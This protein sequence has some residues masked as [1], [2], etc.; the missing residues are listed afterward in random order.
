MEVFQKKGMAG[1]RVTI[2]L[3]KMQI[4]FLQDTLYQAHPRLLLQ[5]F[6]LQPLFR[7]VIGPNCGRWYPA[8]HRCPLNFSPSALI[9]LLPRISASILVLRH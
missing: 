8:S 9:S 4:H 7:P 1:K 3:P 2:Q 5:S 6:D